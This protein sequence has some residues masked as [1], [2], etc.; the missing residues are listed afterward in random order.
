MRLILDASTLPNDLGHRF[1]DNEMAV[2]DRLSLLVD[3]D[4]TEMDGNK[5]ALFVIFA[6]A[7]ITILVFIIITIFVL[8][9]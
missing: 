5:Y 8:Y 7:V 3:Q 6:T 9:F 2:N 4:Y 1:N